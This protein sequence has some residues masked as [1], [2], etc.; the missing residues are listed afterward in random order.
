MSSPVLAAPNTAARIQNLLQLILAD[1]DAWLPTVR[2][3]PDQR[4]YQRVTVE[5]YDAEFDVE[6]WLLSWLPGQRTG[7][8][9][10]GGASGAF[11]V[12]AG[13]IRE[14]AVKADSIGPPRLLTV[15][16]L[17]GQQRLFGANHIHEIVNVGAEPAVSVHLYSPALATMTRY[18]WSRR[19]PVVT[20]VERAGTDW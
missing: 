7:L 16:R 10:H 18:R 2:F 4:R 14:H 6:A 9:D 13:S 1:R 12:V 20:A 3:D 17:A 15:S 19:G 11:A 5:R 8:H